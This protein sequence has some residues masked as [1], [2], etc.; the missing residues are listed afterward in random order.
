[1]TIIAWLI[2]A[3]IL[4]PLIVMYG[5]MG[6]LILGALWQLAKEFLYGKV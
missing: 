3:A 2:V 1:M 4:I 6:L 5:S